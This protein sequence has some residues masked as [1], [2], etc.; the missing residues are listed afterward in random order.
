MALQEDTLALTILMPC[1]NEADAVGLCVQ[2]A[3][4]Y[5]KK[6]GIAGE[7]LVVDNASTDRSGEI[8]AAGGARVVLENRPGYGLALRTGIAA[9]RGEVIIMG[10]CDT[11][12]DFT[13]LDPLRL[14]LAERR[15]DMVIGDRFLGGMEKGAMSW[16]HYFGV[17]VL[18]AIGRKRYRV[19]VKDFH[20]GLRGITR[21]AAWSLPF[22][23]DVMEFATEMIALAAKNGLRIGQTPV[24]LYR[25][26]AKRKSK[27]HTLPDGLRHLWY[28]M[29]ISV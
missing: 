18:S 20:C 27:L 8:A 21:R 25:C 24:R 23:A 14:L 17:K 4:A 5:L 13:A 16:T 28:M 3:L 26:R 10:D 15:C 6:A 29:Q 22:K 9:S 11:T 2:D 19:A 7:I 1:R 12:Y